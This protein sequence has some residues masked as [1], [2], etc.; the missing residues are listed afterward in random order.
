MKKTFL[1]LLKIVYSVYNTMAILVVIMLF[2]S[3]RAWIEKGNKR[4]YKK[5]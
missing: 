2:I 3:Q 1:L 4:E 5:L